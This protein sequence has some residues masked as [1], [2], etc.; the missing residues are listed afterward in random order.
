[1]DF[2]K[3]T[4][5]IKHDPYDFLILC[6]PEY[7]VIENVVLHLIK[8]N[9]NVVE[10]NFRLSELLITVPMTERSHVTE[11]WLIDNLSSLK[12]G[13]VVCTRSDLLFEP[14]L[15]IDP[16]ALFRQVARIT[17]LVVL[18][19]GHFT[20]NELIYAIPEHKHYRVWRMSDFLPYQ[21]KII[22]HRIS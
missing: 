11:K 18:W 21:P 5:M 17:R 13:P 22:L 4:E 2:I 12:P 6:H 20:E 8:E 14:H 9:I 7:Q 19:L 10:I 3:L 16:L 15:D 1:M